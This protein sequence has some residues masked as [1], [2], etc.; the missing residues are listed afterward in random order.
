MWM[1]LF[2]HYL[3]AIDNIYAWMELLIVIACVAALQS[4][5]H[6]GLRMLLYR[7]DAVGCMVNGQCDG[8]VII[9]YDVAD[10]DVRVLS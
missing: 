9:F 10:I 5:V 8:T 2:L 3:L 1:L 6:L 4:V 7:A